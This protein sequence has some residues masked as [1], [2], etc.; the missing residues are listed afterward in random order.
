M[1]EVIL[2]RRAAGYLR[3]MPRERQIQ[4]RDALR[5]VAGLSDIA[6]H[7]GI[8]PLSGDLSGWYRLRVGSYRAILQLR[9]DGGVEVVFVDYIGPRGDAY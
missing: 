6:S 8:K 9:E 3:R 5:T 2:H 4:M 1:R 7:P